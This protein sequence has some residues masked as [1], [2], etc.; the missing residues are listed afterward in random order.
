[1]K[2]IYKIIFAILICVPSAYFI[3]LK[4]DFTFSEQEYLKLQLE[5]QN[6]PTEANLHILSFGTNIH[7]SGLQNLLRSSPYKIHILGE[8][9]IFKDLRD[10]FYS[11]VDYIKEH[12]LENSSDLIMFTDGYDTLFTPGKHNITAKF[13]AFNRPLV[14][15]AEKN[16]YPANTPACIH[17]DAYPESH[18]VFRYA[19]SGGYL[20]EGWAVYKMLSECL[21]KYNVDNNDQ[22]LAHMFF[23][24]NRDMIALD[25]N[26][27]VFS[28]LYHTKFED[29]SY[30]KNLNQ[31]TNLI[32]GSHPVILHGNGRHVVLLNKLYDY[33][34]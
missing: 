20:G 17:K 4:V 6:K 16:C 18:N 23:L 9:Q 13:R 25:Y 32:T 10:K 8:G 7:N 31:I 1:M 29:Y 34:N 12:N 21:G 3:L 15:S 27:D 14:L 33:Y 28:T 26:Q 5:N 2:R 19:N 11:M 22:Y 30:D 24:D